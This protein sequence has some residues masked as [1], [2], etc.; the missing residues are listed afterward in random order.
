MSE[1]NKMPEMHVNIFGR[2]GTDTEIIEETIHE[3]RAAFG[4]EFDMCFHVNMN[5]PRKKGNENGS[6]I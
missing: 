4:T 3:M 6:S 2:M 5:Q 1:Q